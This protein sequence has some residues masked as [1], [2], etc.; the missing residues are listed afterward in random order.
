MEQ[1]NLEI[2]SPEKSFLVKEDTVEVIVPA[3]EGYMGILKDH[4]P[5]I[6]FLKPGIIDVKSKDDTLSFYIDDGIVEFKD[7]TLSIL[8]SNIFDLINLDKNKIDRIAKNAED[9]L[10]KENVS[11]QE[12]FILDQKIE[13]LNSLKLN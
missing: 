2:I 6:S 8:T 13:I 11:D 3:I 12:R 5:I 1:F 10:K 4:I 9:E 7:N